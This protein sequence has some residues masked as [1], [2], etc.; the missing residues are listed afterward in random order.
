MGDEYLVNILG[1]LSSGQLN[2]VYSSKSG[3]F[4]VVFSGFPWDNLVQL[5]IISP[6]GVSFTLAS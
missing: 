3:L 1:R 4:Q 2:P 6:W 5:G